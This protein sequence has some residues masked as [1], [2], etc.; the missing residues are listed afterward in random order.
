MTSERSA[1]K[2]SLRES[3]RIISQEAQSADDAVSARPTDIP[4][5]PEEPS[6]FGQVFLGDALAAYVCAWAASG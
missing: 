6:T 3:L 1:V 4:P 5:P 2:E